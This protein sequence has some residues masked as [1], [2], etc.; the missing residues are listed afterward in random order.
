MERDPAD[1]AGNAEQLSLGFRSLSR[2][3]IVWTL[4]PAVIDKKHVNTRSGS[5]VLKAEFCVV[6]LMK[7]SPE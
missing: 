5:Y 4:H 6:R 7:Q 1:V 3:A 2:P